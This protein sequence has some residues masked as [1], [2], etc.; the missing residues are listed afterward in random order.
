MIHVYAFAED[1]RRVPDVDGLDGA[2]LEQ[3]SVDGVAA[4][5]SRRESSAEPRGEEAIAHGT[6]VGA[7]EGEATAVVPVRYGQLLQDE[8]ALA[9]VLRDQIEA[10]RATFARVRDCAEVAVRVWGTPARVQHADGGA[11][12]LHARRDAE[13]R[14]RA[15]VGRLHDGLL[16]LSRDARIRY[17]TLADEELF[18]AAYLVPTGR[19][20][21]VTRTIEAFGSQHPELTVVCTGPWAPFSFAEE[22]W[23]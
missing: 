12:Y 2:P 22:A 9:D 10:I 20:E 7:L 3:L 6:V 15:I 11:G 8:S 5:F 16:G 19:L 17:G 13:S 4:V 21:D 18:V 14:R 23:S 1:L